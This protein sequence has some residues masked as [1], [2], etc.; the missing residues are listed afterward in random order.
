M[1]HIYSTYLPHMKIKI[2]E[3]ARLCHIRKVT[4]LVSENVSIY[5]HPSLIKDIPYFAQSHRDA[6][7]ILAEPLQILQGAFT[8]PVVLPYNTC[9]VTENAA[10]S[11]SC[12]EGEG[13]SAGSGCNATVLLGPWV[14]TGLMLLRESELTWML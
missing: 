3:K 4:P 10:S 2:H 12:L 1:P 6:G 8:V 9:R 7:A 11:D 14:S 5:F 13:S